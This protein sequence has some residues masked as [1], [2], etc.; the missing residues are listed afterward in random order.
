MTRFLRLFLVLLLLPVLLACEEKSDIFIEVNGKTYFAGSD[1]TILEEPI[2]FDDRKLANFIEVFWY[3]CSHCERFEPI[4]QDWVTTL[5]PGILVGRSPAVWN[6]Q[7]VIHAHAYHIAQELQLGHDFHMKLFTR[8]RGLNASKDLDFHRSRIASLFADA[9]INNEQYYKLY[10]SEAI[11]QKVT[12]SASL[13]RLAGIMGTPSFLI[14]GK[15]V[16]SGAP[17]KTSQELLAVAKYL[18]EQE[19]ENQPIDWW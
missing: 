16:L 10:N 17:F 7:T 14:G 4:L 8:I 19:Q 12:G 5:P 3:G 1:F 15:Y 6:D 9:G 11:R 18:L 2:Q 13:M